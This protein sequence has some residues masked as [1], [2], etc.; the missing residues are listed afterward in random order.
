MH[1]ATMEWLLVGAIAAALYPLVG[2]PLLLQA[3]AL[4]RPRPVLRQIFTPRVTILIPAFNEAACIAATVEN[5]LA[6]D[7]PRELLEIIVV[8]DASDDGTDA[9]VAT[10]AARGV[11]LLRRERR[12]GK[13]AALNEAIKLARGEILI[14]SDANSCFATDAVRRLAENFADPDVGYVTGKLEYLHTGATSGRGSSAYMRYENWLRCLESGVGSVIGVNGGIDAMRSGLYQSVPAEQITDFVLPLRVI[15]SGHRV[16]YDERARSQEEAN[17]ELA[18]EFRMRVRV[19]LRALNGLVY[20]RSALNPRRAPLA[21]FSIVSHKV[22][23]YFSFLFLATA[24]ICNV[25]LARHGHWFAWLL[26]CQ[27]LFYAIAL[28]GLSRRMP[29]TL[30]RVAAVPT[31]FVVSNVAFGIA[32]LRFARGD[33]VSTWRPRAG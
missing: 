16:V 30:R 23:R 22:L 6:Q 17:T 13:A 27:L 11:R 8:S 29:E 12:E 14:F 24:L 33:V 26:L 18:S 20:V 3:I 4:V 31:Y 2:Y 19:A 32:A 10:Y 28:A 15:A 21:A 1:V 9:I 7:Y 5:K 25:A